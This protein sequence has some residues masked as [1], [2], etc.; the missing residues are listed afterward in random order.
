MWSNTNTNICYS[1]IIRIP[2]YLLTSGRK[3]RKTQGKKETKGKNWKYSLHPWIVGVRHVC[4]LFDIQVAKL[5]SWD[6]KGWCTQAQVLMGSHHFQSQISSQIFKIKMKRESIKL[7]G[8]NPPP[9]SSVGQ[10]NWFISSWKTF[11]E[12]CSVYCIILH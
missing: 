7:W 4:I 5:I 12:I 2:N 6:Y 1:N 10:T 11:Q 8:S 3:L 9:I